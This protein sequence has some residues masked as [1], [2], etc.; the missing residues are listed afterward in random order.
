MKIVPGRLRVLIQSM[1]PA[2]D[3]WHAQTMAEEMYD[4][5]MVDLDHKKKDPKLT[6]NFNPKTVNL[7]DNMID[8]M[9]YRN[10]REKSVARGVKF[11][12]NLVAVEDR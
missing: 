2:H 11:L 5:A 10:N 6:D 9:V 8:R 4:A 1:N 12:D 7:Y 3:G